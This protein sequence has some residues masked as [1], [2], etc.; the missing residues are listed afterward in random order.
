MQAKILDHDSAGSNL[1]WNFLI[2]LINL[3]VNRYQICLILDGM[4]F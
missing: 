4:S 2:V 3:L 1:D